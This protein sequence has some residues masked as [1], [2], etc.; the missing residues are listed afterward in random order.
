MRGKGGRKGKRVERASAR[1]RF[2]ITNGNEGEGL[3]RRIKKEEKD[4]KK[5]RKRVG[6]ES[7][8]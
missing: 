4:G 1:A 8:F 6:S 3:T 5:K 7:P 2:A